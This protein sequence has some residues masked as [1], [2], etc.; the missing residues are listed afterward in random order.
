MVMTAN[1]LVYAILGS[2]LAAHYLLLVFLITTVQLTM[3]YEI[4]SKFQTFA[5]APMMKHTNR[6]FR[7]FWR[8]ISKKSILFSEMVMAD[9]IVKHQHNSAILDKYLGDVSGAENPVVLQ[10]GGNDPETLR[11]ATK[12]A[13]EKY[14]ICHFD[15]NCGCPSDTVASTHNMGAAMMLNS[16]LTADCCRAISD[17][18]ERCILSTSN[19]N[20]ITASLCPVPHL[21]VKCRIGI[22][23]QDSYDSL[24]HFISTV[25]SQGKVNHF[26]IHARKALLNISAKANRDIPPLKH[27]YVYKLVHDFPH[28]NFILNGGIQ[29]FNELDSYFD[30][31][32]SYGVDPAAEGDGEV[33]GAPVGSE[34]KG[35]MVGRSCINHPYMWIHLDEYLD[36]IN[37]GRIYSDKPNCD[38]LARY[39]VPSR[40]DILQRYIAYYEEL[41]SDT[42]WR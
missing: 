1:K 9:D 2:Y 39:A 14:N 19:K 40:G 33:V 28:I 35:L 41:E 24:H 15:L 13:F 31:C 7:Y 18:L 42:P 12:V 16:S 34:L 23:D 38:S 5:V 32:R 37:A 8:L 3:S 26:N 36:S 10:L 22:D 21:S 20:D 6:H 29:N 25:H 27:H 4:K 30:S 11:R 17:E